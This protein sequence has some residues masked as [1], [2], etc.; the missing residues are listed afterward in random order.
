M[1]IVSFITVVWI[2]LLNGTVVELSVELKASSAS[3]MVDPDLKYILY[4]LRNNE[5]HN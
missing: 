1:A 5:T 2:S 4:I 3:V